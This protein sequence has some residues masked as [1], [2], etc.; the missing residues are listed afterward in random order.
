MLNIIVLGDCSNVNTLQFCGRI[1]LKPL[2]IKK[3]CISKSPYIVAL[4]LSTASGIGRSSRA[5]NDS[6]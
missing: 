4:R 1:C 5:R 6:Y 3:Y 2:V